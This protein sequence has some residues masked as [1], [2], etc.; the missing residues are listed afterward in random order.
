MNTKKGYKATEDMKC[1]DQEYK[2]GV[3]YSC[4]GTVV[5]CKRGFHYCK[6]AKDVIRYY[7]ATDPSFVLLEVEDLGDQSYTKGDKTVTNKL[8]V[9]RIVPNNEYESLDLPLIERDENDRIIHYKS[10]CREYWTKYDED[11]R[12]IYAKDMDGYE[13]FWEY[14][15]DGHTLREKTSKGEES[16]CEYKYEF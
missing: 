5:M 7:I 1:R 3:T 12:I 9:L 8:K 2:V 4:D 16:S 15:P 14:R 10:P 6:N 13:R 11:G